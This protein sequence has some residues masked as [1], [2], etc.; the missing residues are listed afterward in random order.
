MMGMANVIINEKLQDTDFIKERCENFNDFKKSL[1]KFN[2]NFV[3]KITNVPKEKIIEAAR[4]YATQRPS[5][6]FYSMGITQHSHGT[7]NVLATSNLALLTGNV[8]KESSGVNPLRGQNNVQ[9]ACDLGAL[10]NVYPGYQ[11]VN[12]PE[13][14]KKFEKAWNIKLDK[15]PGLT[16]LEIF[17]AVH[18]GK[19]KALY[20]MGENPILSEANSNHVE[21]A[22]KKIEFF[23]VQDIFLT[24]TAQLADVVLP[25]VS[26]AEKDGTFTN[27]ER[28]VQRVRRAIEHIG[29]SKQ[30]WQIICEIA[31]KMKAKGFDFSDPSEI[32]K[33]IASV[34]PIYSGI[35]YERIRKTGLQWPCRTSSDPGTKFLH[36]EKFTTESGKGNFIPLEYK[37]PAE[38]PDK[39]YPIVLTTDRS[40]YH[41]HTS[42]RLRLI[43]GERVKVTSRRGKIEVEIKITDICP[44]GVV[45]LTFHFAEAPTNRLTNSA[46]DPVSKIPET[47]VCAVKIEKL[48]PVTDKEK[49]KK[50]IN[51]KV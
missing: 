4:M 5:S 30:D 31:K 6:L 20:I 46:L 16:H 34:S 18:S 38:N 25:G 47:K 17:D 26:F 43:D 19:V 35:S 42:S 3:Q 39:A 27:T 7:D 2:L 29:D 10:P 11:K 8:G 14:N 33:E 24:E 13:I 44:P 9:G 28:R 12:I 51:K 40:L 32:M 45:S 50:P 1:E 48:Q 15:E 23:V 22:I 49:D 37:P 41:Y 36:S 21:E